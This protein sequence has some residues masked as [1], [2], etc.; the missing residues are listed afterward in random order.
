MVVVIV[1]GTAMSKSSV[2]FNADTEKKY[3][4]FGIDLNN[5]HELERLKMN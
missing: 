1:V 2:L 5:I 4:N 3:S